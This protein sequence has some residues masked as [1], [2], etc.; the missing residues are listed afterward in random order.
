MMG[1]L[2]SIVKAGRKIIFRMGLGRRDP[3]RLQEKARL[4][5]DPF[6]RA[7][8][9]DVA[10]PDMDWQWEQ[11]IWPLIQDADFSVV[12][13]LIWQPGTGATAPSC[14]RTPGS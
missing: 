2:E 11:L 8:Y 9:Y 1:V 14:A 13:D 12:V 4:S 6:Q 10:E 7:P 3:E 5:G